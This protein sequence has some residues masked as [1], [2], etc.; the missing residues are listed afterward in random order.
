VV[1]MA[2]SPSPQPM[3][4]K[5]PGL[6]TPFIGRQ[7]DL[8]LVQTLLCDPSVRLVTILGAGGVGKT[9]LALKLADILQAQFQ[10][11][12][13]F[14]PLAQL[15]SIDDLLPELA[16]SLGVQLP[17]AG[18]LQQAL[19]DTLADRQVLLV[20]DNFEH[21]LDE[22]MLVHDMLA[23]GP[24]VKVLVTSR[25]KL[26]LEGECLYH[27]QGLSLPPPGSP[28]RVEEFDAVRL[29]LQK[30]RQARPGFCMDAGNTPDV[31]RICQQVDGLPLGIL[32][33]A[34]WVEHF[35]PAE[36]ASQT[37]RSLDFLAGE[38]RDAAPRH[39]GMRAVFDSSY[40]RLDQEQKIIFRR[41]AVF[42]GGFNLA[43]AEEVADADLRTLLVLVDKSLLWRDPDSGRY[44]MHELLRQYASEELAAA[45]ES[46]SISAAHANYYIAFVLQR[47][48]KLLSSFQSQAL[49]EIQIDFENIR[50]ALSWVVEKRNFTAARAMIPCLYTFCDMRSRFYEGEAI[51]RQA[52]QGLSDQPGEDPDPVLALA[53]LSWYDMRIYIE[54][55]ES[56]VE[57]TSQAKDCLKQA[58]LRS[59]PEGTTASLVLLG[60]I[61]E[62]QGNLESAIRNYKKGLQ[63][64]AIMDDVY[65]INI[66]IG[67]CHQA[68][69][70]YPQAIQAFQASWRRGKATGER[71]KMGWSLLNIGDTLLLQGNL[72]EAER[73][74]EQA[75]SLF[76]EV[77]TTVGVLWANYSLSRISLGLGNPTLASQLA[78]TAGQ[79]ARQIHSAAWIRKTYALLKQIDPGLEQAATGREKTDLEPF[80]PREMEI[81]RLLKSELNGPEIASNLFISVNTVRFHTKN[82]Y[83]KLRVNN[84]LEAIQRAKEL[85]L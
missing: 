47:Q 80:S 64:Q 27:L 69:R 85:G 8:E 72:P 33:A 61:A 26:N 67:L 51:F 19:M 71:V 41:L 43:A 34:A 63:S 70:E 9:R 12:V 84:R 55:F 77:G 74:L 57:L 49:D 30:A 62:N 17:P 18:D 46:E 23:A 3:R 1:I 56:Y 14:I 50:L 79:I 39:S 38:L 44:D 35:S 7:A 59:D 78:E 60:A 28:Q 42:R 83:Q 37:N 52:S 81:L 54:R 20:L 15:N 29:F 82:I 65:W 11:G 10:H 73:Y 21:L 13:V 31:V 58:L 16:G 40:H 36:I 66:R 32:L 22:A 75:R 76:D 53:L 45:G 4:G 2:G 24:Q 6:L 68:A 25:E 48:A 5:L